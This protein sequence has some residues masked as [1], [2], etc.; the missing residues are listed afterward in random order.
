MKTE[1]WEKREGRRKER[2]TGRSLMKLGE[3]GCFRQKVK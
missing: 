1:G 3:M 2:F